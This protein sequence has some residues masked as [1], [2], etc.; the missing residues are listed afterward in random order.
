MLINNKL[1]DVRLQITFGLVLFLLSSCSLFNNSDDDD[2]ESCAVNVS[3]TSIVVTDNVSGEEGTQITPDEIITSSITTNSAEVSFRVLKVGS[4][5]EIID[6][7]HTWSN[8]IATPTVEVAEKSSYGSNVNFGDEVRT[9]M[10]DLTPNQLYYVRGYVT[11][12]SLN[13]ENQ[14]KTL[15]NDNISTFMTSRECDNGEILILDESDRQNITVSD[16]QTGTTLLDFEIVREVQAEC[17]D[18]AFVEIEGIDPHYVYIKNRFSANL[19]FDYQIDYN[20]QDTFIW[21]YSGNV[22]NIAPNET[23]KIYLGPN[24]RGNVRQASIEVTVY[25]LN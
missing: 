11:I 19:T 24:A 13:G 7:G 2:V 8:N 16:N 20:L 23:Q 14:V 10:N 25:N 4:C 21:T 9:V 18:G 6:Y 22:S 15:Y 17:I 12:R 5:H 1:L 3:N